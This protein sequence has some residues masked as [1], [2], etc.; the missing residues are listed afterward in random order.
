[1]T[2]RVARREQNAHALVNACLSVRLDGARRVEGARLAFGAIASLPVRAAAAEQALAGRPWNGD[3]LAAALDALHA[4]L[5]PA[6][7]DLHAGISRSYRL[8]LAESLLYRFFLAVAEA[9]E[10]GTVAP[11]LA[12]GAHATPR[13]LSSGHDGIQRENAIPKLTAPRQ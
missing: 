8:A 6:I 11:K 9:T 12:G 7:I 4:E 1:E 3:S 10:P 2:Y 13:P 5:E